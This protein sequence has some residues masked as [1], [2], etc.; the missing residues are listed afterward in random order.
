MPYLDWNATAP[1]HPRAR[2]AW[3]DA[4]DRLWHNPSSLYAA[5]TRAREVLER[6]RETLA[7][8]LGCDPGR[9]VFTGGATESN[10]A[11]VRH[12]VRTLPPGRSVVVSPLEHPCLA[13]PLHAALGDRVLELPVDRHGVVEAEGFAAAVGVFFGWYPARRAARLDPIEALR[14]E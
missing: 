12:L 4:V 11:L 5:A 8:L 7:D 6:A 14:H 3:L 2:A 13:E 1:L 9:V 10:N